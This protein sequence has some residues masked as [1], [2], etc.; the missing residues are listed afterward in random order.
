M[1]SY[2][3]CLYVFVYFIG[4]AFG[5]SVVASLLKKSVIWLLKT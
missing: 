3:M 4:H 5:I 2:G 1:S